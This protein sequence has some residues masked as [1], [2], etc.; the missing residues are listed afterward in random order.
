MRHFS[1]NSINFF[2]IITGTT[3]KKGITAAEI[4][5]LEKKNEAAKVSSS[6][7]TDD[8]SNKAK[9]PTELEN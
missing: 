9:E 3:Q 7:D 6:E 8:T 1:V 4:N 5:A 2:T